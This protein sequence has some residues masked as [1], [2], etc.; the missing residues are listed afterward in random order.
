[1]K[2]K[3]ILIG[4]NH[5]NTL[6]VL[7]SL[8]QT[9]KFD[10]CLIL[11]GL[12]SDFVACSKYVRK[13]EIYRVDSDEAVL[14]VLFKIG[15]TLNQKAVVI[16]SSDGS[17][18]AI[19]RNYN[20]LKEYFILPNA[21]GLE[22]EIGKLMDKTHQTEV[23]FEVGFDIPYTT[24]IDTIEQAK[25]W[26]VF[27]CIIKPEESALGCKSDI[28]ICN[29]EEELIS[30]MGGTLC[31]SFQVQQ[32][33]EKTLEFQLIGCSLDH[34]ELLIIP[35]FT[36]IIRQPSNTN[37]G[38]LKYV[39]IKELQDEAFMKKVKCFMK[40]IGYEGLFSLEFLQDKNGKKYF[41]EINMRND[42][43]AYCVTAAGVNLPYNWVLYSTQKKT[44]RTTIQ[45]GVYFMPEIEDLRLCIKKKYSLILWFKQFCQTTH[46]VFA[47]KDPLPIIYRSYFIIKT[48]FAKIHNN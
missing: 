3:V 35:G 41:L 38:Y 14:D 16:C 29:D 18:A 22:G 7:R 47:I 27:P 42:G 19:D 37:T 11:I 24:K 8:G 4:G 20:K 44:S 26:N 46:A 45:K 17:I 32:F 33:I 40:H 13:N 30:S 43:N 25:Q 10:V 28:Q 6:G 31:N 1:M 5:H 9:G 48:L 15:P 34:G 12:S 36:K 39:D 2:H 21:K 23:A